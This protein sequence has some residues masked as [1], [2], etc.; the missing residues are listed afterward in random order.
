MFSPVL[1]YSVDGQSYQ[2]S[3]DWSSSDYTII[4]LK[5]QIAYNPNIQVK[6]KL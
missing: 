5:K 4:G 3:Q 2:F 1:K 6:P